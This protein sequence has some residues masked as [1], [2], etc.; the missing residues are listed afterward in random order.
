MDQLPDIVRRIGAALECTAPSQYGDVHLANNVIG[1][2]RYVWVRGSDTVTRSAQL[3]YPNGVAG[4][5]D[6]TVEVHCWGKNELQAEALRAA[7]LNAV[8]KNVSAAYCQFGGATWMEP[9]HAQ[10]GTVCTQTLT[11]R[12]MVPL[13]DELTTLATI[14]SIEHETTD[15]PGDGELTCD[16]A[17]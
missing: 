13:L 8:V 15:T 11:F 10:R 9:E 6:S 12:T 2:P 14:L 3:G 4:Q 17:P 7:L 5:V 16:H 1:P